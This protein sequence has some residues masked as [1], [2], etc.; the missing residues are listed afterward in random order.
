MQNFR[1]A[2]KN[3]KFIK[4]SLEIILANFYGLILNFKV[5]TS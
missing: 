1:C 3:L 4:D 5:N 2:I